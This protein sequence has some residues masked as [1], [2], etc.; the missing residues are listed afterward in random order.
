MFRSLIKRTVQFWTMFV[1]FRNPKLYAL[2]S[3]GR[4]EFIEFLSVEKNRLT[5]RDFCKAMKIDVMT[6][7]AERITWVIKQLSVSFLLSCTCWFRRTRAPADASNLFLFDDDPHLFSVPFNSLLEMT[8]PH[9]PLR[10][11]VT[12]L[13]SLISFLSNR[14]LW[15]PNVS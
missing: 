8:V 10:M 15:Y 11:P 2:Y 12:R 13:K 9:F 7:L 4:Y 3:C 6:V 5:W 14:V 1:L